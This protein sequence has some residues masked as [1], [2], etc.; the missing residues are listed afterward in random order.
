MSKYQAGDLI[1]R[2]KDWF[3]IQSVVNG[4][5]DKIVPLEKHLASCRIVEVDGVKLTLQE[6]IEL[7]ADELIQERKVHVFS[8][9]TV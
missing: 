1:K 8:Q 3:F 2:E 4:S 9:Q 7:D 5:I 6:I